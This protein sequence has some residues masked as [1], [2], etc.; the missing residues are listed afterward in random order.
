MMVALCASDAGA[1]DSAL[2][3]GSLAFA[4]PSEAG[5]V[6]FVV[7][8]LVVGALLHAPIAK[9]APAISRMRKLVD[10]ISPSIA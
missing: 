6:S 8:A 9:T 1:A 4:A 5:A 10:V 2:A 3:T 7:S